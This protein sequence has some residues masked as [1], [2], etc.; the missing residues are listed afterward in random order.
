M[1]AARDVGGA[2]AQLERRRQLLADTKSAIEE[3]EAFT[4]PAEVAARK[5][6][7]IEL[8]GT[9]GLQALRDG[10]EAAA[11]FLAKGMSLLPDKAWMGEAQVLEL[12]GYVQVGE[13][14]TGVPRWRYEEEAA[15][16]EPEPPSGGGTE[17]VL[18]T[19]TRA[20]I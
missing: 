8:I 2:E 7:L 3:L 11:N 6:A 12:D 4:D 10:S 14:D 5:Q 19:G 17:S 20:S 1:S 18:R 15:D 16:P 13:T 9:G